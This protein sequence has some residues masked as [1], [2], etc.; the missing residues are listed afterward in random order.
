[1]P[2]ITVQIRTR[3]PDQV[4]LPILHRLAK[5]FDVV[6][7]L[8][9]AR[10]DEDSAFLEVEIDGPLVDAQR[11]VSWLHTTGLQLDAVNRSV[12]KDSDNL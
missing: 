1:M 11:A 7:N 2:A 5:D 12:G 3:T 9:R 6:T 8:R 10:V 4:N